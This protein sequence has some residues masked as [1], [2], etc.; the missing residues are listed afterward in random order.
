[1]R[2]DIRYDGTKEYENTFSAYMQEEGRRVGSTVSTIHG[3]QHCIK[4][5]KGRGRRKREGVGV[6]VTVRVRARA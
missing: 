4:R 3:V 5:E 2:D 1:M 6:G